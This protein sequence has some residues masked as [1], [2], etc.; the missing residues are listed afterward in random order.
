MTQ[1]RATKL[2]QPDR[3]GQL[4]SRRGQTA[5]RGFGTQGLLSL[6]GA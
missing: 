2:T 6:R 3:F 4:A 1:P 5:A